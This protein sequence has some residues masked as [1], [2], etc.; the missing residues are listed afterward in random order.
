MRST[1]DQGSQLCTVP[2]SES[3]HSGISPFFARIA[4]GIK[5]IKS[6]PELESDI[7]HIKVPMAK[8]YIWH[9]EYIGYRLKQEYQIW[10]VTDMPSLV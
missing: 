7:F 9:V 2:L 1:C 3:I 10:V 4:I 6:E 5:K 8:A